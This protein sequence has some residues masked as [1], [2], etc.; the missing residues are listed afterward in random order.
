MNKL[1]LNAIFNKNNIWML[2]VSI[3]IIIYFINNPIKLFPDPG[4]INTVQNICNI[5]NNSDNT[6]IHATWGTHYNKVF[7]Y[8]YNSKTNQKIK[9]QTN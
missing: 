8:I 2:A 7:I 6:N 5:V 1:T 4:A 3:L 9:L